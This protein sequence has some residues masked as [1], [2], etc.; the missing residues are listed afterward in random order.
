METYALLIGSTLAAGTVLALAA[1][2]LLI[3][4]RAGVVNLGAEGMMICAALAGFAAT[5]ATGQDIIGFVAGMVAGAILAWLAGLLIIYLNTNAYATGLA[6]SLFGAGIS[7]FVGTGY[8]QEKLPERM[9]F[10]VPYLSDIP[11]VGTRYLNNIHWF[12]RRCYWR[13]R[14]CCFYIK[15]K[16]VSCYVR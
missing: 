12:M 4:E 10:A 3:N 16:V 13:W 14:W 9:Q 11:F 2:G 1:L 6:L 5:H 15:P 8:V 7:A